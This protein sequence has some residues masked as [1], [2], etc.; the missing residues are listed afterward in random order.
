MT[1]AERIQSAAAARLTG[2]SLRGLQAMAARGCIP[3]AAKLGSR[4]T[5]DPITLR[6]WI[7]SQERRP[8]PATS[9]VAATPGGAASRSRAATTDAVY[10]RAIGLR[11]AGA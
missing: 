2:L 7:R 9:I 5:F 1:A 3:G 11:R 10:E 6:R 8:C 4:W